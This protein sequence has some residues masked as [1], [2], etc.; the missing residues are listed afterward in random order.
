MGFRS[1]S[2]TT[3]GTGLSNFLTVFQEAA[4]SLSAVQGLAKFSFLSQGDGP[5]SQ[6]RFG[7]SCT[8]TELSYPSSSGLC[9]PGLGLMARSSLLAL[10]EPKGE[11]RGV[12]YSAFGVS[13]SVLWNQPPELV[14]VCSTPGCV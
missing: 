10:S 3:P 8:L 11:A 9:E 4:A 14:V 1:C 2:L 12:C 6:A 5:C 7:Q 13:T